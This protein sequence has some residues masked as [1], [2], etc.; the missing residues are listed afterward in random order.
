MKTYQIAVIPGDGI[1]PEVIREAVKVLGAVSALDG[2]FRFSFTEYPWG[3]EYYLKTGE[4]MPEDGLEQLKD[5]D[6]ILLGAVGYP[7]VPDHISLRGLL[8]KLRR[9]FDQYINLR[10][11]KLLEGAPCPLKNV[12][13]GD[14]DMIFVR[15]N[16][17]GEY[18]G[19]G[20][21]LYP[22]SPQEIVIQDSVF[23]RKGC[24]RVMR[25]AYELARREGKTLTSISKGN[26]LNYSMVF[27][28]QIFE[29]VGREYPDVE[30][31]T[32]LVDA[33]SMFMIKDPKRFQIVVAS[34]LFGDILTDL[35]ASISGGM[36]LAA[37][38]NLDP[39]RRYPSM[40]EP[41]HGSAPRMAGKGTADPLA[42]IWAA[43][44]LLD[45][46]GYPNWYARIVDTIERMLKEKQGLPKDLGGTATTSECGDAFVSLLSGN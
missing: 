39:E 7:G 38:A 44:Q 32:L 29:E 31:N 30:T 4:M 16:S 22:D 34:N 17:E 20:A 43:A 21:W 2:S 19:Q 5:S 12:Q 37:G 6:A 40:F 18:S 8:L 36:G 45:H 1:G 35:G 25:Y 3:C 11:V 10:P 14:I 42:S 33:A 13:S 9:G 46:L 26:A 15:E 41:I 23:S 24:E 27:W 28:D